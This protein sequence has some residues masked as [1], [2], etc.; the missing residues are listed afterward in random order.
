MSLDLHYKKCRQLIESAMR[1]AFKMHWPPYKDCKH[2]A[3]VDVPQYNKDG[4]R[5]KR[6]AVMYKCAACKYFFSDKEIQVDHCVPV[7]PPG[8]KKSDLS[9]EELAA[10][11]FCDTDNLQVLCK[12]CHSIKSKEERRRAKA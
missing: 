6:D 3:R 7:A 10:R 12:P 5:S 8:K 1:K 4:T 11:V 9:L 2:A